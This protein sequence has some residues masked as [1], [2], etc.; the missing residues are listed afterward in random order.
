MVPP[1]VV[2]V[3]LFLLFRSVGLV[4]TYWL[5]E[6]EEKKRVRRTAEMLEIDHF[7]DRSPR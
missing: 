7:L 5:P 4:N 2:I 1:I 6:E 3:P